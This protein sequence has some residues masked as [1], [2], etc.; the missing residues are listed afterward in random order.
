MNR[1]YDLSVLLA[2]SGRE[3]P[4]LV[5]L[6]EERIIWKRHIFSTRDMV[7]LSTSVCTNLVW[8]GLPVAHSSTG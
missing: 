1:T 8:N 7:V 4:E 5:R 3:L 6:R 2:M